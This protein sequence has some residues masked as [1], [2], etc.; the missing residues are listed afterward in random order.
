MRTVE[1]AM[2]PRLSQGRSN[3][4]LMLMADNLPQPGTHKPMVL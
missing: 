3:L 4:M 2:H 1:Y